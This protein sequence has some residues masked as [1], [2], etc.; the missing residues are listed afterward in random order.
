MQGPNRFAAVREQVSQVI[1]KASKLYGVVLTP[2]I[3]FGLSGRVAG[4]AAARRVN[5]VLTS[6]RLRFNRDV[7]LGDDYEDLLNNTIPHEVAHLVCFA[8]P[9][10][11]NNHNPGWKRVCRSLGGTGN[12]CHNYDVKYA[13][14]TYRYIASCG[15][16]V[17][18]SKILHRRIQQGQERRLRRTGGILNNSCRWTV[19]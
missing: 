17:A 7:I 13:A 14:G 6:Q 1:S 19:A 15:T 10:L 12:R 2:E 8:R 18:I 5:G 4:Q 11:G 3:D 16:E 9:E